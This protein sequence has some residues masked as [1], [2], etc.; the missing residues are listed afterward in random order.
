VDVPATQAAEEAAELAYIAEF[1][2]PDIEAA[3]LSTAHGQLGFSFDEPYDLTNNTPGTN[4]F[5]DLDPNYSVGNFVLGVD[6]TWESETGVAGCGI[7]FR[8]QDDLDG[9]EQAIFTAI[10]LSGFPGWDIELWRFGQYQANLV[11]QVRTSSAIKQASGSTNHYV[12]A[13]NGTSVVVY[14]NGT[15]LGATNLKESM[16]EGLIGFITWQE[17]GISTCTF[18]NFWLWELDPRGGNDNNSSG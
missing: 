7:I 4:L 14:A 8:A 9:G 2:A 17:S 3:G 10:R 11:G 16:T 1:I 5:V 13:A 6:V 15:R 18:D 12:I